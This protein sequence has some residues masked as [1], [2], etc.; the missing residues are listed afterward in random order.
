[1]IVR[2][3]DYNSDTTYLTL[4]KNNIDNNNSKYK[5]YLITNDSY[6]YVG[7][8]FRPLKE[9]FNKHLWSASKFV[10]RKFYKYFNN[11]T[12]HNFNIT[13]LKILNDDEINDKYKI[14]SQ[15]IKEYQN[16]Y[17]SFC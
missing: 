12:K 11:D 4:D 15:F 17:N 10:N 16:K 9:R 7:L 13:L 2:G 6:Y 1:M 8:T 3:D 5:I 14:E